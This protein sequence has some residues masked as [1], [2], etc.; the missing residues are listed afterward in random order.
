MVQTVQLRSPT[1]SS[2]SLFSVFGTVEVPQ[3]QSST[4]LNDDFEGKWVLFRRIFRIF[5][6][7]T[8]RG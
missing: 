2:T 1:R 6:T 3:I 5:Q 7:L 8:E 4:V